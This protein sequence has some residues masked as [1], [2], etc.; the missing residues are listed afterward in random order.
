LINVFHRVINQF[1][2][3]ITVKSSD[4]LFYYDFSCNSCNSFPLFVKSSIALY[5]YTYFDYSEYHTHTH[6][7]TH[8]RTHAHTHTHYYISNWL[9][10]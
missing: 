7:H 4:I 5:Y 3:K 1:N 2:F 10:M 9:Y 6:A 8:A